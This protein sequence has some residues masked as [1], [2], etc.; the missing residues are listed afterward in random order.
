MHLV[1]G[2]SVKSA[3][4]RRHPLKKLREGTK[5]SVADK[6]GSRRTEVKPAIIVVVVRK[7][8]TKLIHYR[9]A[10]FPDNSLN[11]GT[12]PLEAKGSQWIVG[13]EGAEVDALRTVV[14]LGEAAEA[15]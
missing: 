13:W 10:G 9:L 8:F 5:I 3:A 12:V 6:R 14:A 1:S 7:R 11:D 2:D 15:P 4:W